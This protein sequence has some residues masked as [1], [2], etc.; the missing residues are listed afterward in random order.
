MGTFPSISHLI[1]KLCA[2]IALPTAHSAQ[3]CGGIGTHD[4]ASIS[5]YMG[6]F[7]YG[8]PSTFALCADFCKYDYPRCRS[9]RYWYD[10]YA[11]S[12]Y[13]EFFE[14]WAEDYFIPQPQ[15]EYY[16]YDIDC[17]FPDYA[18]RETVYETMTETV[19]VPT[20][21]VTQTQTELSTQTSTASLTTTNTVTQTETEL[22][23]RTSTASITTTNTVTQTETEL[24]IRTSTA[25]ITSTST[26]TQT[27]T[28][29]STRTST[30]SITFTSTIRQTQTELSTRISTASI[31][32]TTSF[33]VYSRTRTITLWSYFTTTRVLITSV[34]VPVVTTVTRTTTV[35]VP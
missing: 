17:G 34:R 6:N 19:A 23:I 27:Q 18:V 32:T 12:Q 5:F 25:S 26:V 28:E 7:F 10:P 13:C 8:A 16:Y 31:T 3:I 22:S 4:Y 33:T 11:N 29:L 2:L 1:V 14:N 30:A 15:A 21:T 9:F 35:R 24:S 20:S